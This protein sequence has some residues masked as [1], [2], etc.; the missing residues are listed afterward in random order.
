LTAI[1]AFL[2]SEILGLAQGEPLG[3]FE[4]HGDIGSPAITGSASYDPAHQTYTLTAGGINIW[5]TNDQCH[6]LW[7]TMNGDFI[8]RARLKL[9]DGGAVEHRKIGWMVRSSLAAN[10]AFVDG[11]VENGVG[12][13]SLQ[14]RR[15]DGGG[16]AMMALS[17]TKTDVVQLERRGTNYIFSAALADGAFASTNCSRVSLPDNV[18]AGLCICSHD[19]KIKE[20]VIFYDVQIIHPVK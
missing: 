19:P 11:V 17:L 8:L 20:A 16:S 2:T 1:S 7:N 6:F 10:A 13:T 4:G 5:G 15:F 18:F 3:Q 12:L 9:A 14:Y